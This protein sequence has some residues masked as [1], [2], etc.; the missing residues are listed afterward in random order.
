MT[1]AYPTAMPWAALER[2]D[3][4]RQVDVQRADLRGQHGEQL[5]KQ[6][7]AQY[8][9]GKDVMLGLEDGIYESDSPQDK[10]LDAESSTTST[11]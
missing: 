11:F 10:V 9:A 4:A 7:L 6:V 5:A 1:L 2:A 3:S 8:A